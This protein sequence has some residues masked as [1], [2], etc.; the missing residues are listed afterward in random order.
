LYRRAVPAEATGTTL[1]VSG[2]AAL[3]A[4]VAA[5][6]G[7]ALVHVLE[8]KGTLLLPPLGVLIAVVAVT[9]VARV[10]A[11]GSAAAAVAG[12]V[13]AALACAVA[14]GLTDGGRE[15]V[16]SLRD[17]F[18][19][20]VPPAASSRVVTAPEP[21]PRPP[22]QPD[23]L[24][25]PRPTPRPVTAARPCGAADLTLR[26]TG[27][28]SAMGDSSVTIV[29]TNGSASACW[30]EGY[31]Q[32]R[33]LQGGT[34]LRLEVGHPSTS[35]YGLPLRSQRVGVAPG[36]DAVFGWWWKGYRSAADQ[37]TPQ[38]VLLDLGGG[39]DARLELSADSY[40]VD[41][42]DGAKVEV[43]PWGPRVD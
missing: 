29:A 20:E 24:P 33:L 41:V 34:D 10:P 18:H 4:A 7:F 16:R 42:I 13:V 11:A 37:T 12:S 1:I 15:S 14:F 22:G 9:A 43:T 5:L 35:D 25:T 17:E 30:V 3:A 28:D 23:P 26:A 8:G 27:W 32:L 38:T 31:P 40:L 39:A 2:A 21:G 19:P 6:A 36:G